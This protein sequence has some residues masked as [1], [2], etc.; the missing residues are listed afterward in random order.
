M[1]VE[2]LVKIPS[3]K[4]APFAI[5]AMARVILTCTCCALLFGSGWVQALGLGDIAVQSYFGQRLQASVPV[6]D[7]EHG[8]LLSSCV[9]ARALTSGDGA[10]VLPL[11]VNVIRG[12]EATTLQLSSTQVLQELSAVIEINVACDAG[13]VT[14]QFS[15]LLDPPD[16]STAS[17]PASHPIAAPQQQAPA[18]APLQNA[19]PRNMPQR[20]ASRAHLTRTMRVAAATVGRRNVLKLGAADAPAF[21]DTGLS[22][23]LS[24]RLSS[25]ASALSEPAAFSETA[26]D[27]QNNAVAQELGRAQLQGMQEKIDAL[28]LALHRLRTSELA[29]TAPPA[30]APLQADTGLPAAPV[31]VQPTQPWLLGLMAMLLICLS[32]I[33]WLLWRLFQ[34]RRFHRQPLHFT[35]SLPADEP[36]EASH[37]PT[38][39]PQSD[40]AWQVPLD[41]VVAPPHPELAQ[42]DDYA[43]DHEIGYEV[44]HEADREVVHGIDHGIDREPDHAHEIEFS[45][46]GDA[47]AQLAHEVEFTPSSEFLST[48][49]Q[50]GQTVLPAMEDLGDGL[51]AAQTLIALDRIKEAIDVLVLLIEAEHGAA[52]QP[53]LLLF[54]LYY[55]SNQH[56]AYMALQGKFRHFFNCNFPDWQHYSDERPS[57]GLVHMDALLERIEQMWSTDD[58]VPFLENLLI[59][60]RDGDRA[61]FA[62]DV[63]CDILFL[64]DIAKQLRRTVSPINFTDSVDF[65][66]SANPIDSVNPID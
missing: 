58:I 20:H 59:D 45:F 13:I 24:D 56:S 43:A 36:P 42:I 51:A 2:K 49:D 64:L 11:R 15:I 57:D 44:S 47:A 50:A 17:L 41:K 39:G 55:Q 46:A 53:F 14:R 5:N 23:L 19:E 62:L 4:H 16:P 7:D 8:N 48:T 21:K 28:E 32:A 30:G 34:L 6:F 25:H 38:V 52:P 40:Y 18:P 60:D 66:D 22:L 9:K 33:L 63:F 29:Q 54:D 12:S 37:Q 26:R 31:L 61:G 27:Q 65:T 3:F 35:A 1:D 10:F